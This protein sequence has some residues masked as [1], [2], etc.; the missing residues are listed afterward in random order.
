MKRTDASEEIR[1]MR[2][3][4]VYGERQEKRL[5]LEEAAQ[6]L[7]VNE[8]TFRRQCQKY[9]SDGLDGLRDRRLG[10]AAH[11]AAP[12]DELL[13][14]LTLYETRYRHF[15]VAHFHE[16]WRNEHGGQRS[17]TWVKKGLQDAGFIQVA[18]KRGK[19][20]RKRPRKPLPGMMLHQDGSTHEW[21]PGK[22]WDLIV[23][24]D[25]ATNTLYSAIFVEEEGT[26]SSFQGVSEVIEKHGLFCS[27]YTDR[28]SHYWHT[29]K[30]GGKVDRENLTQFG[31]AMRQ[32]GIDMIAAYSPE[33]RGRSERV[34]RTLQDR[35][36][37]ELVLKGITNMEDAN[38]FLKEVFLP[39]Y[40]K[41]FAVPAE[42]EGSAFVPWLNSNANLA[43]FLCI[44]EQ[45]TVNKDNTVSYK[46]KK[47]QIP[48][49][50]FRYHYVKAKVNIYEYADGSVALLHGPKRLADYDKEGN[51][52]LP[53]TTQECLNDNV[54]EITK[55]VG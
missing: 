22:Q 5:T 44:Q 17:Y 18:K 49:D 38:T 31:R 2:F 28:G 47:F 51:L 27:F 7:G 8:R 45:R 30:A 36:P 54:I 4:Q 42:E 1:L 24:M 52:K 12:V 10:K 11:N 6:I 15:N 20:R 53:T 55:D 9:E 25:D 41:V 34:F 33:A 21:V 29:P 39:Q 46:G 37:K 13:E 48:K 32:L 3:L 50:Q 26:W 14:M 23:T 35:L 40:N 43:D 16:K 19:H